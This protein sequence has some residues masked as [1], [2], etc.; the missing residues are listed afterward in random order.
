MTFTTEPI[1]LG[2]VY[3][4]PIEQSQFISIFC[5]VAVET[6]PHRLGM[7]KLDLCMFFFQFPFVPIHLQ[8]G[9]AVAAG[10]HSLCHWGRSNRELFARPTHQGYKTNP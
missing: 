3:Q 4:L 9:M 5:F 7:M 1:A 6:P 10:K 8:G 2:E